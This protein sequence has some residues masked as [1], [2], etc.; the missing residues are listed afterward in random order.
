[1]MKDIRNCFKLFKYGYQM[2]TNMLCAVLF[3]L[4]GIG[5]CAV[6]HDQFVICIVYFFLSI[7]FVAQ[8]MYMMLF[9]EFIGA[10]PKRSKV[11][12][13]YIDIVNA[14]GG[15]L[16]SVVTIIAAFLSESRSS[17][18]VSVETNLIIGGWMAIILYCYMSLSFKMM[19]VGTIFFFV[20]F[21]SVMNIAGGAVAAMFDDIFAGKT[22]LAVVIFLVEVAIGIV[23]GHGIR[24]LLYRKSMSR[25][26]AGAKLRMEQS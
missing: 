22:V 23:L 1:M 8:P 15:I 4:I 9:S 3:F 14:V 21:F 5:F 2:K 20:S 24:R 10:S 13:R 12:L 18:S 7:L 19:V 11:E 25:W 6:S 16:V 26:A 17:E